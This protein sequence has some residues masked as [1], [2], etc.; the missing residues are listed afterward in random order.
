MMR[1]TCCCILMVA[2][3][4]F[5]GCKVWDATQMVPKNAP[6]TPKLVALDRK[7]ENGMN[8][9][10]AY[11]N[12]GSFTND[13]ELN[14][15]VKEVENNLTDPYTNKYGTILMKRNVID[16]RYG[17]GYL[18]ASSLLITLPNILGLP[19]AHIR[20]KVEVELRIMDKQNNLVAKYIA[21]G[22]SSV[23]VAYY[24]GYSL[25]IAGRKSYADALLNALDQLRPQLQNDA[26]LI[27]KRLANS[28]R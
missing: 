20:Y 24:Y 25:R 17:L 26:I 9:T 7:I 12:V 10:M 18:T 23:K 22:T 6:L 2:G 4:T 8:S 13:D 5:S 19:F 14:L 1:V 15:F 28:L 16:S 11:S 21:I 3:T 27:N